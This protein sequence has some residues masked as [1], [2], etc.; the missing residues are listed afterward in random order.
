MQARKTVCQKLPD[1]FQEQLKKFSAF[2]REEIAT[3]NINV[4]H[5]IN[6]DDVPLP[7][8]IPLGRSV[9]K[10]GEKTNGEDN[11]Q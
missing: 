5:I 10:K 9:P 11:W 3:K 6:M 8:D 7:F 1:D 2:V 4:S